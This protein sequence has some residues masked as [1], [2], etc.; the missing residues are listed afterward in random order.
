MKINNK[1]VNSLLDPRSQVSTVSTSYYDKQ[2]SDISL[3]PLDMPLKMEAAVGGTVDYYGQITLEFSILHPTEPFKVK[4]VVMPDTDYHNITHL[5]I[6]T[7]V[8]RH[9]MDKYGDK[10][11]I[12]FMQMAK[13]ISCMG[14]C[15]SV[16][17]CIG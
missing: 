7:A 16:P 6:E 12:Q 15:I 5:A 11:G 17:K 3:Q 13:N 1:I 2:L 9:S 14:W 10:Y 4:V 8:L